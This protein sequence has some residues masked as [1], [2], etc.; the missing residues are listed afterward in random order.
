MIAEIPLD[1]NLLKLLKASLERIRLQT[2]V[3]YNGIPLKFAVRSSSLLEDGE[4]SSA[5]GQYDTILG[6]LNDDD[7][8]NGIIKCWKS[9]FSFR[10]VTYR[11]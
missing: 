7:I 3:P 1:E 9:M 2:N 5:A 10:S 11:M 8:K 6:C 4:E